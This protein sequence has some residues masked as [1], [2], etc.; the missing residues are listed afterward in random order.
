MAEVKN[1][2]EKEHFLSGYEQV[3][4]ADSPAW[5][6]DIRDAGLK[7]F[8]EIQLPH[9]KMEAWRFTNVNPILRTQFRSLVEPGTGRLKAEDVASFLYDEDA[10]TQLVFVDGFFAPELSRTSDT[11]SSGVRAGS[12]LEALGSEQELLQQHLG[13]YVNGT[14]NAFNALNDAFLMDGAFVHIAKNAVAEKPVHLVYVS[15]GHGEATAR[16]PRNLI[17]ADELSESTIIESYVS[18]AGEDTYL[19]NVVA[20]VSLAA[21][22][23]MQR[24]KVLHESPNGYHL[25]STK[26]RQARDSNF[27]SYSLSLGGNIGRNE[28]STVLEGENAEVSFH[29]LYLADGSQ[30]VDNFTSIEHKAPHCNSWIGYKGVLGG[31]GHAV[32]TGKIYVHRQAQKT[33][34]NQL[35][36]NL[37]LSD[38]A[39]VDTKPQLEIFA[40][41]VKCTHGATVGQPPAEEIYYFQTR[42]IDKDMAKGILT[43]GFAD[44]VVAR[45]PLEAVRKR[46]DRFVFDK[47]GPK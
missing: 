45:L 40:D 21:G 36:N 47:Y 12:L 44:E 16:H 30:L 8:G 25:S 31:K 2:N 22:A 32:F 39:T 20:E 9:R 13:Q 11:A 28:L 10:W 29:G 6:K 3:Q 4:A 26:V 27:R 24:I 17:L 14:G 46:L 5:V 18:L 19:N 43:Y 38:K 34:S 23:Q 42:G 33:D 7:R 37:L 41:D 15:T 35:N 1:A